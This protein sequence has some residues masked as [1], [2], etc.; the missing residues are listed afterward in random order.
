MVKKLLMLALTA[1]VLAGWAA[2]QAAAGGAQAPV[3]VVNQFTAKKGIDWPYDFELLQKETVKKVQEK[4][5]DKASVVAAAPA[6]GAPAYVLDG[7]IV[8]MYQN[9]DIDAHS[10]GMASNT[11][12]VTVHYWLTAP[13]GHKA[14][15]RTATYD[16]LS[17]GTYSYAVMGTS[18][19]MA[20]DLESDIAGRIHGARIY[21]GR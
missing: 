4:L 21:S 1:A 12:V 18:G 19:P 6:G 17:T 20:K 15:D 11:V 16:S 3:I 9:N 2:G 7:Q 5:G 10:G 13:D 14:F 8:R